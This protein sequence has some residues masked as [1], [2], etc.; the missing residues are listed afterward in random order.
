VRVVGKLLLLSLPWIMVMT[1]PMSLLFGILIAI[2]RLSADSELVALRAGG[3]SLFTLYRP[4][5]VLSAL[6]TGLN[7]Y[8]MVEV[9]PE[10]NHALQK[11]RVEILTQSLTEEIAPRIPHTGWQNKV[12]YIFEAPPGEHRW[13]GTFLADAIPIT[14]ENELVLAEWGRAQAIGSEV[15]LTLENAFTHVVDLAHPEEYR[16]AFHKVIELK[17]AAFPQQAATSVSRGLRELSVGELLERSED[18][19]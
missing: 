17:L 14:E 9:L 11:L 13:K 18:L 16:L 5:L 7:V 3:V 1:I 15:L 2:G 10:G 8:L 6:L 4:I 19:N 12:L